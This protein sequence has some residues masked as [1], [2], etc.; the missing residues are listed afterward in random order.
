[1]PGRAEGGEATP[2]STRKRIS[3]SPVA[4]SPA[5]GYTPPVRTVRQGMPWPFFM[6]EMG[7]IGSF[8]KN[9]NNGVAKCPR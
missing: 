1:M 2:T 3:S 4:L 8:L 6:L 9:Q 5:R 7:F